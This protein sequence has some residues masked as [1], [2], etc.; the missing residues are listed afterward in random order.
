MYSGPVTPTSSSLFLRRQASKKEAG[1]LLSED[2][3]VPGV[4]QHTGSFSKEPYRK[5]LYSAKETYVF[6]EPTNRNHPIYVYTS[7]MYIQG[8][9][10]P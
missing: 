10:D 2:V 6:R 7:E 5:D 4:F 8:G 9:E 1:V 3:A